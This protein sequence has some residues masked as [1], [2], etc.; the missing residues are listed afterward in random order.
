VVYYALAVD[1]GY[2]LLMRRFNVQILLLQAL[3]LLCG[4][5]DRSI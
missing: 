2:R 5:G 3:L 1:G 4:C